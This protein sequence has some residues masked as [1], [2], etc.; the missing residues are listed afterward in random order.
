ML[1]ANMRRTSW[2]ITADHEESR[3]IRKRDVGVIDIVL[4]YN[5][6]GDIRSPTLLIE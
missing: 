3:F 2:I 6:V 4:I 5:G 1:A